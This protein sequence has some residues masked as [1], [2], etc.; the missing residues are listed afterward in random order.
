MKIQRPK[1]NR[2]I[3]ALLLITIIVLGLLGVYLFIF[4]G[5]LLGWNPA[6]NTSHYEAP[7]EDQIK[8]GKAAQDSGATNSN[9]GEKPND[10]GSD[11]PSKPVT[12]PKE[13]KKIA[14]L[15]ISAVNQNDGVLQI[16]TLIGALTEEGSCTLT[17]TKDS[18]TLTQTVGVQPTSSS[19]T[20][21]GF[22][23]PVSQL[24][25]GEWQAVIT[26]ENSTLKA[27]ATQVV[28]VL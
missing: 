3:V 8:A 23:V 14:S 25:P 15:V 6:G 19:T 24:S 12:D 10:V 22:D 27:R 17:L 26:F 7:T 2:K 28:K 5:S 11:H 4:K 18:K 13:N 16:R 9:S 20:C 1:K 21:K